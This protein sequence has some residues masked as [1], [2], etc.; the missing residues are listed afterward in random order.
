MSQAGARL[1][2]QIV[3]LARRFVSDLRT[4]RIYANGIWCAISD[5]MLVQRGT[6][7]AVPMLSHISLGVAD[8]LRSIAF[9]DAALGALGFVRQWTS[10]GGAE[11]GPEGGGGKLAISAQSDGAHAPGPGFHL[12]FDAA[13][14]GHVDAFHAAA[15]AHEG[16][17]EGAPGLR[18]HYGDG[19]YAAFVRDPDGH[20]LEAVCHEGG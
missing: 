2:E 15:L 9:Y 8:I 10:E 7:L 1:V 18:P 19:Y 16:T 11:Y 14:R 17:D 3:Q 6:T 12:A 4:R 20:K 13:A 5:L